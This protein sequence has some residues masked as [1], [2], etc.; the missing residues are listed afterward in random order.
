MLLRDCV[1]QLEQ[2]VLLENRDAPKDQLEAAL[3]YVRTVF[4][5]YVSAHKSTGERLL[6]AKE[7][8]IAF[9][10]DLKLRDDYFLLFS[11]RGTYFPDCLNLSMDC[12]RTVRQVS[13]WKS[14]M[15]SKP[16]YLSV[17][18]QDIALNTSY[19]TPQVARYSNGVTMT[20]GLMIDGEIITIID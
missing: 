13:A 3:F 10:C 15:S 14:V 9:D 11:I 4:G 7:A 19:Q 5:G 6:L 16:K 2:K 8:F 12:P 17:P 18:L 1:Y 20:D